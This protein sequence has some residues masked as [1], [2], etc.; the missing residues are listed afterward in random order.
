MTGWTDGRSRFVD[1]GAS[2]RHLL[3]WG[4]PGAPLVLLQ[5][6][7]RDH[8]ASWSWIAT[9][10]KDRY[11]VV[12]PDLRG[13]GDSDWPGA[14]GYALSAFLLDL[15]LIAGQEGW[16][17]INLVGHSLGGHILLRFA[18]VHPELCRS[19]VSIEGI[20]LPVVWKQRRDPAPFDARLR[21]WVEAYAT[22]HRR[23]AR[24]YLDLPAATARMVAAFPEFDADTLARLTATGSIEEPGHGL[25][26]KYDPACSPRPPEDQHGTDLDDLLAAVRCPALL[27]YGDAS[28]IDQPPPARLA[29]IRHHHLARF[30]GAS[31]W[32]HHQSREDFCDLVARFLADPDLAIRHQ[33]TEHA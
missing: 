11:H 4:R 13:H 25:R 26:W 5:H 22:R 6:G 15:S 3:E 18:A 28:W 7:L 9:A 24:G 32:L 17:E 14:G 33:R 29:L 30:P 21:D 23:P 20:E 19:L 10:L 31:H 27:A 16:R 1:V 12:A 2:R 8:A